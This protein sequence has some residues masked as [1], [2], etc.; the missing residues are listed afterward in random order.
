MN[1]AYP[2]SE[3]LPKRLISSKILTDRAYEIAINSKYVGYQ[4]E[5]ANMAHMV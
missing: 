4:R 2:D 5:L 3:D 1:K